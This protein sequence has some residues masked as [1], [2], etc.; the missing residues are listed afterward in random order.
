MTDFSSLNGHTFGERIAGVDACPRCPG[1]NGGAGPCD[2]SCYTSRQRRFVFHRNHYEA[3]VADHYNPDK[4][5]GAHERVRQEACRRDP[6]RGH[7]CWCSCPKE[8]LDRAWPACD[9]CLRHRANLKQQEPVA[10]GRT[11]RVEAPLPGTVT[12]FD[13]ALNGLAA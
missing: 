13:I 10:M 12:G 5:A 3:I 8:S 7:I 2:Q 6:P 11:A 9:P 4:T 1:P